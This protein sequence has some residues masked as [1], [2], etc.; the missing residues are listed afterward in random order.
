MLS[1]LFLCS[2][3]IQGIILTPVLSIEHNSM[4]EF[5]I[6]YQWPSLW[7]H[8]ACVCSVCW[9]LLV[10]HR[11]PSRNLYSRPPTASCARLPATHRYCGPCLTR[12][13]TSNTPSAFRRLAVVR[14]S[15]AVS[16]ALPRLTVDTSAVCSHHTS[17]PGSPSVVAFIAV[18]ITTF[19]SVEC[20]YAVHWPDI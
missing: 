15:L 2:G 8:G 14:P 6:V 9:M 3:L 13:H 18:L 1:R 11:E 12:P 16:S 20:C 4:I 17:R 10:F 19:L 7:W 5:D